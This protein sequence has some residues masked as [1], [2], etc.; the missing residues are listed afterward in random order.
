MMAVIHSLILMLLVLT[1]PLLTASAQMSSSDALLNDIHQTLSAIQTL[2]VDFIQ[3][4]HLALFEDELVSRGKLYYA[5]PDQLRWEVTMPYRSALIFNQGSLAKFEVE[6]EKVRR[7][8][9]AGAAMFS[10]IMGQ[11]MHL[12]KGNF[13]AIEKEYTV[14]VKQGE[15]VTVTLTP[16]SQKLAS[17]LNT[18]TFTMHSNTFRVKRLKFEEGNGDDIDIAFEHE[19][20]NDPLDPSLFST[21][22]PGGFGKVTSK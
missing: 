17:I 9:I 11:M 18:F 2:E 20:E 1:G 3:T 13:S 15:S 5:Q 21:Q 7:M 6:N 10:E 12:L 19:R 8:N 22:N 14:K 16:R 4:R